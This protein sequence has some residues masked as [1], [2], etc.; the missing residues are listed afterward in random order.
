MEDG[1]VALVDVLIGGELDGSVFLAIV[2]EVDI[3]KGAL[4][5]TSQRVPI[6]VFSDATCESLFLDGLDLETCKLNFLLCGDLDV[7]LW[8]RSVVLDIVLRRLVE[9]DNVLL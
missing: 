3:A 5:K 6:F 8:R 2:H 4:A 7:L 9:L 1:N